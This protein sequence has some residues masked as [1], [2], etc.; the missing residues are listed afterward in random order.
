[1]QNPGFSGHFQHLGHNI[2]G[3][4]LTTLITL[5]IQPPPFSLFRYSFLICNFFGQLSVSHQSVRS[6]P[7]NFRHICFFWGGERAPRKK[8]KRK[9]FFSFLVNMQKTKA[10]HCEQATGMYQCV[11]FAL[12]HFYFTFT[13]CSTVCFLFF[14]VFFFLFCNFMSAHSS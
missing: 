2:P 9:L 4:P 11:F 10:T 12:F 3:I 8:K 1:M 14:F 5:I 13:F 6:A 7:E